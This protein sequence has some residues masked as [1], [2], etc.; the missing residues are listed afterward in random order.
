MIYQKNEIVIL[1]TKRTWACTIMSVIWVVLGTWVLAQKISMSGFE[2]TVKFFTNWTF[3]TTTGYFY[4]ELFGALESSGC[5]TSLIRVAFMWMV[6][7]QNLL[8]F[9]LVFILLYENWSIMTDMTNLYGGEF[10][11]GE[12]VDLEKLFHVLPTFFM[13]Y[14]VFLCKEET[15]KTTLLVP[16][17]HSPW[18]QYAYGWIVVIYQIYSGMIFLILYQ[19]MMNFNLVYDV[20]FPWYYGSALSLFVLSVV[21]LPL[22]MSM[23]PTSPMQLKLEEEKM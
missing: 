2:E 10:T 22:Y 12:I 4:L 17:S 5:F 3:I 20:L 19:L 8:V 9:T 13:L 15:K 23:I 16:R 14:F 1:P 11:F 6:L 7:G 18:E 21:I